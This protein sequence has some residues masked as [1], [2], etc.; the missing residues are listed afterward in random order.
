MRNALKTTLLI[1]TLVLLFC[2]G[3]QQ[4]ALQAAPTLAVADS[5]VITATPTPEP[6]AATLSMGD[7]FAP[8]LG[9]SDYDVQ[10]YDIDIHIDPA[11]VDQMEARVSIDLMVSTERLAEIAL[12]FIGYQVKE[13]LLDG[14]PAEFRRQADK[15]LVKLIQPVAAGSEHTIEITYDGP[16]ELRTSRYVLFEPTI[17]PFFK[18]GESFFIISEPDGARFWLPCNDHPRD[19]ATFRISV[20][21]PDGFTAVSNGQLVE[22]VDGEDWDTFIWRHDYPMATYA[23]TIAV[24]Q[25]EVLSYESEQGIFM[26]HYFTPE[27]QDAMAAVSAVTDEALPWFEEKFGPYPFDTYGHVSVDASG[28]AFESQSMVVVANYMLSEQVAVH[29]L[30]HMWFGDWVSLDSWSEMWR[31]EGFAVYFEGMWS[32]RDDPELFDVV[33]DEMTE[34][35]FG[36]ETLEPLDQLSPGNLFGT[37]SYQKGAVV[38]HQLRR[39]VGDQAFFEG[40]QQ[41]FQIYGGGSASDEEFIA[42]MEEA[43]GRDLH[44]FFDYWL[45]R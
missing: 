21:V 32:Y 2:S 16:A 28:V 37:E 24:D 44:T 43:A 14:K 20:H 33:L 30:V 35:L 27:R 8:E 17:G 31:N 13:V 5:E 41:Y 9:S 4:A 3:C 29:E 22:T 15:L 23:A 10:H 45:S 7:P 39:E 42:V 26:R 40:L 18:D 12:D 6:V 38:V 34:E 19:K 25:Y 36:D 11:L 1:T